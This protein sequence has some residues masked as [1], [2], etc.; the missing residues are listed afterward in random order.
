MR[1]VLFLGNEVSHA[2][3]LS[4]LF[5]PYGQ[6]G[7]RDGGLIIT[8]DAFGSAPVP[9]GELEDEHKRALD[10]AK[11]EA[12]EAVAAVN[13]LLTLLPSWGPSRVDV[14]HY[15]FVDAEGNE[16]KVGPSPVTLGRAIV[17]D[18]EVDARRTPFAEA[19]SR[20]PLARRVLGMLLPLVSWAD[21]YKV[22]E[23]VQADVNGDMSRLGVSKTALARFSRTA[24]HPDAI[25][26]EA[27]HAV[28]N[29]EPP[30]RPMSH[31][32]ACEFVET[33]I[34]AWMQKVVVP[35]TRSA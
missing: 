32:E 14:S 8:T 4:P 25:G 31:Q 30:P 15:H 13:G 23:L 6:L 12:R 33:L 26:D 9:A 7:E 20:D 29:Q 27:R 2:Q 16:R 17:A 28:S 24:N 11:T 3:E 34:R 1:L 5:Q 35:R 22:H 10:A 18:S 19:A 21:L